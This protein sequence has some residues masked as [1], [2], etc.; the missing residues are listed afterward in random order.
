MGTSSD[1]PTDPPQGAEGWFLDY[2][3]DGAPSK[4]GPEAAGGPTWQDAHP[5]TAVQAARDAALSDPGPEDEPTSQIYP[6]RLTSFPHIHEGKQLPGEICSPRA[7][8]RARGL[9][10]PHKLTRP[11]SRLPPLEELEDP[12]LIARK[13]RPSDRPRKNGYIEVTRGAGVVKVQR[14]HE[15][16]ANQEPPTRTEGDIVGL[17]PDAARRLQIRMAKVRS[18]HKPV[19][20][21]LTYP[22]LY[23]WSGERLKNQILRLWKR[24]ERRFSGLAMAW[25]I[26][27]VRRKSGAMG[28]AQYTPEGMDPDEVDGGCQM[29]HVHLLIFKDTPGQWDYSHYKAVR[30]AIAEHWHKIVFSGVDADALQEMQTELRSEKHDLRAEHRNAGTRTERIRSRR[31]TLFYVSEY[32]SKEES[33]LGHSIGRMWGIYGRDAM[34]WGVTETVPLHHG[35]AC[36]MMRALLKSE[37][38]G[39]PLP[40]ARHHLC[41]SVRPWDVWAR[42]AAAG[43]QMEHARAG[44]WAR[45]ASDDQEGGLPL[46]YRDR[47]G[48]DFGQWERYAHTTLLH[49][50]EWRRRADRRYRPRAEQRI[51]PVAGPHNHTHPSTKHRGI[52]WT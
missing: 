37:G 13:V 1:V 43:G 12:Q 29:P 22:D 49:R 16:H 47:G 21:T 40:L 39:G 4:T 10:T 15:R 19:F 52:T 46:L 25:K 31:G 38:R 23:S 24:L 26:E 11:K 6:S 36:R 35:A 51:G 50:K 45:W 8:A 30:D 2:Y 41:Q 17:S 20:A 14:P 3:G 5:A 34:P 27:V 44:P 18:A 48:M 33:D 32:I 7:G 9:S 28:P 42:R